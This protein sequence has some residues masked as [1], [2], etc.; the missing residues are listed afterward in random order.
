MPLLIEEP[1]LYRPN[2]GGQQEFM[3]DYTHR[4][5]ALA[6]GWY[7]GKTWAGARKLTD[8][9]VFNAFDDE[10]RPTYVKSAVI[11]PTYQNAMDFDVPELQKAFDEAGL[12]WSFNADPQKFQFVL[13]DLGTRRNPSAIMIRTADKPER[14]TGWTVGAIWGD[15]AARWKRDDADPKRDPLLQADGRL[16]D[17]KARFLQF[18]LTFTHEGDTTRVYED[19]EENPKPDHVLY[20][21]GTFDNPHARDFADNQSQQL[22][23]ELADQYLAGNAIRQRG[24]AVYTS[25]EYERNTRADLTLTPH[26]PLQLDIDFNISPGMHAN[27]GQHFP[28]RDMLTTVYSIHGPAMNVRTM[29][30]ALFRLVDSLGGWQWPVLELF[31]DASGHGRWSGT[32]QTN[33]DIVLECLKARGIPYRM[34][35]PASN[36]GVADRV[37]V[38]NCALCDVK[39][40]PHWLIHRENCKPLITDLRR[41]KWDRDGEL[42]KTDRK[43]SHPSDAAGYRIVRV[44]PIRGVNEGRAAVIFAGSA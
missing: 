16:R 19:F 43:L 24:N 39:G 40:Q 23:K 31:G 13:H 22:T 42:D 2:A 33:W 21:A 17:V 15:E 32:G 38:V 36:P 30:D 28:D 44:R 4:Y 41:M 34:R 20:R 26:V 10:G 18:L 7:A 3:D 29:M 9:H 8:L 5:V 1:D 37:N 35:V 14:I 27:V 12:S 25:F 6:G 11:A